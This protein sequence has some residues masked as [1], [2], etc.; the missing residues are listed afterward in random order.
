MSKL[1]P[2]SMIAGLLAMIEGN[3]RP[4]PVR[5]QDKTRRNSGWRKATKHYF[6]ESKVRRKMAARSRHINWHK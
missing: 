3:A 6:H 1:L 5:Q 4:A 2:Q